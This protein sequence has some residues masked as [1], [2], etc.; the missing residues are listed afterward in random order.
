MSGFDYQLIDTASVD[1]QALI[2]QTN[3]KSGFFRVWG[4]QVRD[5]TRKNARAKGGRSF[6][7]EISDSVQVDSVSDLSATIGIHHVA[8]AQKQYGGRI[9]AKKAKALTI[10]IAEE[11]KRKR[12]AE[13]SFKD[14]FM[15]KSKRNNDI[16]G[17][18]EG[19]Q[20]KALYLLRKAVEQEA[21]PFMPTDE[22]VLQ[23]GAVEALE[24]I[25][26]GL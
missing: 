14:L 22:E 21:D 2:R 16:L 11:A 15:I 18:E 13:F 26:K 6:W 7:R 25:Q 5:K 24:F 17:Y 23:M 12:V 10:P 8:A 9:E 20:F 1:L 3:N 19:R 4:S